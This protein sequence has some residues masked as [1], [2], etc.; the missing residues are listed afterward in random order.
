MIRNVL[1]ADAGGWAAG[2]G[3]S[4]GGRIRS[5]RHTIAEGAAW[6]E[7]TSSSFIGRAG[8]GVRFGRWH[9]RALLEES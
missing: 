3:R 9:T 2:L 4:F 1:R 8:L 7:G 5:A 6:E